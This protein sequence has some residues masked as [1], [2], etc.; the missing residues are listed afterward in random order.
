[1]IHIEP[2]H[3]AIIKQVLGKHIHQFYAFGSRVKGT[4]KPLSDLDL[5]YDDNIPNDELIRI[6]HA[7]DDS[8]L[9]FKI[10]IVNS[11]HCSDEFRKLIDQDK[12]RLDLSRLE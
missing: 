10:D 2:A 5:V 6:M 4:H 7:F 3:W 8:A 11:A 1:M 12:I 9:P